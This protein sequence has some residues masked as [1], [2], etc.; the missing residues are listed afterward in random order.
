M[1]SSPNDLKTVDITIVS[2]KKFTRAAEFLFSTGVGNTY[3]VK[4][5]LCA[6]LE[7]A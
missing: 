6:G 3:G 7:T 2:G 1:T 4:T 5:Y